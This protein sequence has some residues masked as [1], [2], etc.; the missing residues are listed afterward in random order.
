MYPEIPRK[1]SKP[2]PEANDPVPQDKPGLGS[3]T[4][5]ETRRIMSEELNKRFDEWTRHFDL[6]LEDNKEKNTNR[7]S[8]GLEQ[9]ARQ[10]RLATEADGEPD[11]KTRKCTE[12]ASAADRVMNGDRSSARVDGD[13]TSLISFGMIAEPPALPCRDDALV[14]KGAEAPK[15]CLSPVEMRM[16]TAAG[17]LLPPCIAST[18]MRSIFP[19]P[20]LWNFCPTE[21]TNFRATTSIQTYATYNTFWQ[22]KALETKSRQTLVFDPGGC[23]GC[24]RACPFWGGRRT[25]LCGRVFVWKPGGYLRLERVFGS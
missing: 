22:M 7:R 18:V 14:D 17:G 9:E 13:P 10:P 23:T 4:T 6:R 20:P 24:L 8:A 19:P 25:L 5:E 2:V 3:L 16:P 12:G 21:E 1:K 11:K 15:P